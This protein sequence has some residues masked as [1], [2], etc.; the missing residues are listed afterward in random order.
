MIVNVNVPALGE[1]VQEATL[2]RWFSQQGLMV[3]KNAPLCELETD[4]VT[5][6]LS[7]PASGKLS[8]LAA[9]G[10]LLSVGATL[11]AIDTTAETNS[12][13]ATPV[14]PVTQPSGGQ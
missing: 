2:A 8:I 9:T 10:A 3:K 12:G 7:A 4:K 1:N 13:A 5:V 14:N 6:K 11:A